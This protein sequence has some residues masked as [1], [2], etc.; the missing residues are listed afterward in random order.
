M[1]DPR[2]ALDSI[3]GFA[4]AEIDSR[5]SDGPTN[6]NWLVE[7]DGERYVLRLDKP[8][9]SRLGL[10]R[11]SEK[12]VCEA[13]AAAGLGPQPVHFDADTGVYLRHFVPGRSWTPADLENRDNL[14]KLAALLRRVHALPPAGRDFKPLKAAGRYAR[15]VGTAKAGELFGQAATAYA[16]LEPASPALCHNDLFCAN[17]LS[18]DAGVA[19]IDWEYAAVGDPFFDLAVVV[20]HHLVAAGLANHFLAAYLQREPS[21]RERS[22]LDRQRRFY[23]ALLDLWNLRLG[24]L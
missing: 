17:I 14:D 15:Q 18:T 4:G 10:D 2:T 1:N 24:V 13:I 3:P 22:R 23:Q 7:R 12:A 19:L 8:E 21:A 20:Q 9:A 6:E 5:H 16:L 11:H